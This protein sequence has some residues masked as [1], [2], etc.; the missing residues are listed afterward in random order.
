[1]EC[2]QG[3]IERQYFSDSTE[4]TVGTE[5]IPSDTRVYGL[6]ADSFCEGNRY[7]AGRLLKDLCHSSSNLCRVFYDDNTCLFENLYL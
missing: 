6:R 2:L 7:L 4:C 3:A 1:M 5:G